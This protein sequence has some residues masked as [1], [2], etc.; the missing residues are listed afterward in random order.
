MT[1]DCA[2]G[3]MIYDFFCGVSVSTIR[4]AAN[5]VTTAAAVAR[6]LLYSMGKCQFE[7]KPKLT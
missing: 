7:Q 6:K 1:V 4:P 5:A 3:I 2:T